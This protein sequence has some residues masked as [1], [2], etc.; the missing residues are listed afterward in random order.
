MDRET[1]KTVAL[2]VFTRN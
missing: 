1:L 2:N